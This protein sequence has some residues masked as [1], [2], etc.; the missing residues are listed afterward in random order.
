[1]YLPQFHPIPENNAWWGNGFTEGTNV[2]KAGP[3]FS[4]HYQPYLPADRGFY[5]LP[6][7]EGREAEPERARQYGIHG[8]CYY[9]SWF[10][11]RRLL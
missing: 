5:N 11:G 7:Y 9:H 2:I 10:N 3:L 4:G 8:S 1:M 6:L